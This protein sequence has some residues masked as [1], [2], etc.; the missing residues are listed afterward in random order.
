M[1][2]TAAGLLEWNNLTVLAKAVGTIEI[3]R[4]RELVISW[5]Y[6]VPATQSKTISPDTIW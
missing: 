1:V 4:K 2:V 3:M 5:S 6:L